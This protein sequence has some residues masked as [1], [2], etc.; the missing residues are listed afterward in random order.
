[1][2]IFSKRFL[3]KNLLVNVC[4][5]NPCNNQTVSLQCL[6]LMLFLQVKAENLNAWMRGGKSDSVLNVFLVD[7]Y[8]YLQSVLDIIRGLIFA[9]QKLS[10][11]V[12]YLQIAADLHSSLW[13][14]EGLALTVLISFLHSFLLLQ[15]SL[16]SGRSYSKCV[17]KAF[18]YLSSPPYVHVKT[19]IHHL[20]VL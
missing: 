8:H 7:H 12:C 5:S 11:I 10:L 2:I 4:K 6:P 18:T 9:L 14:N 16:F 13:W 17:L 1:M 20:S 19:P 3:T 15:I